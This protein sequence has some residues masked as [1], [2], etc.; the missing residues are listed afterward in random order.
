MPGAARPRGTVPEAR[1]AKAGGDP[2]PRDAGRRAWRSWNQPSGPLGTQRSDHEVAMRLV[3]LG[4]RLDVAA[5]AEVLVDQLALGCAHRVKR[6]RPAEA[7]RLV[8]G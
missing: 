8:G 6:N 1:T 4:V 5:I 3:T 2:A 7:Q